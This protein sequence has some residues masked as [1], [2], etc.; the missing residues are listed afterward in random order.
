MVTYINLPIFLFY[1]FL[2]QKAHISTLKIWTRWKVT[3]EKIISTVPSRTTISLTPCLHAQSSRRCGPEVSHP[4]FTTLASC[5]HLVPIV[6][7][8][9]N[10]RFILCVVLGLLI[11]FIKF[12]CVC[13]HIMYVFGYL[14][15]WEENLDLDLIIIAKNLDK[16]TLHI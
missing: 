8:P 13:I 2:L 7:V 12:L 9:G 15:K 10:F 14:L 1:R 4:E 16:L 3:W 11:L 5:G 6:T